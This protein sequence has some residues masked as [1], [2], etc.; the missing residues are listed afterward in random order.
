M[1]ST[2][3]DFDVEA[4]EDGRRRLLVVVAVDSRDDDWSGPIKSRWP[5]LSMAMAMVVA[6]ALKGVH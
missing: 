2:P 3:K 5:L 1:L 4:A 6:M